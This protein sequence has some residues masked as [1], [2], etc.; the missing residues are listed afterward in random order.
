MILHNSDLNKWKWFQLDAVMCS[1]VN[2]ICILINSHHFSSTS[3][4]NT[5]ITLTNF[6]VC[7]ISR[8][9]VDLEVTFTIFQLILASFHYWFRLSP[10]RHGESQQCEIFIM[11]HR[12]EFIWI[13]YNW[14]SLEIRD[15]E[16]H[17]SC[18]FYPWINLKVN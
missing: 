12:V 5:G 8:N 16:I 10:M 17:K 2:P 1:C 18:D 7:P 3:T 9:Y 6:D 4:Y 13:Q 15:M 11:C 14:T